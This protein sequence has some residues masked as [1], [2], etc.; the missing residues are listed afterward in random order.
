MEVKR[1][2]QRRTSQGGSGLAATKVDSP[3]FSRWGGKAHPSEASQ[4][5][6]HRVSWHVLRRTAS[7]REAVSA[8]QGTRK[9]KAISSQ[10]SS[11]KAGGAEEGPAPVRGGWWPGEAQG[12]RYSSPT[13][14]KPD[15]NN[16]NTAPSC[17]S[18]SSDVLE[19]NAAIFAC[20][21]LKIFYIS[22]LHLSISCQQTNAR[23]PPRLE[24]YRDK[25]VTQGG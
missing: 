23:R 21:S 10:P 7:A 24:V 13:E 20:M 8:S 22:Y 6:G 12:R 25:C 2:A 1:G 18:S 4:S 3:L 16:T 5:N 15:I 19:E 9:T 11:G 14:T 17:G